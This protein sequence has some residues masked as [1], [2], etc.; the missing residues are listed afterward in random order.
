MPEVVFKNP[1]TAPQDLL[2]YMMYPEDAVLGERARVFHALQFRVETTAEGKTVNL[3]RAEALALIDMPAAGAM[4]EEVRERTRRAFVAGHL[5]LSMY[6]MDRFRLNPSMNKAVWSMQMY[7]KTVATYADGSR[8]VTSES[9]I[10]D[11]WRQFSPVAHFWAAVLINEEYAYAPPREALDYEH[12]P[13]FLEVA[14]GIHRFATTFVPPRSRPAVPIV[15]PKTT[16]R[17]PESVRPRTLKSDQF[18]AKLV[19]L[20]KGYKAPQPLSP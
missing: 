17:L 15:D 16:W 14:A 13:T 12:W 3:T 11:C 1:I 20:L 9:A 10:R 6:V 8:M 18:P 19:Q 4:D 5:L 7:A 2:L